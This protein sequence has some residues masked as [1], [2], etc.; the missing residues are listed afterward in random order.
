MTPLRLVALRMYTLTLGRAPVFSRALRA[1]LVRRLI[2]GRP[3]GERYTATSR[4]C[5]VEELKR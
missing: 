2:T 3:E 5:D 1:L 4:Y